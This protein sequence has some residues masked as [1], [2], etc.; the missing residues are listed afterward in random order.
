MAEQNKDFQEAFDELALAYEDDSDMEPTYD[1]LMSESEDSSEENKNVEE[2]LVETEE[3]PVEEPITEEVTDHTLQTSELPIDYKELYEKAKRDAEAQ[4]GLYASRLEN[5]SRQYA[6]LKETVNKAPKTQKEEREELPDNVKELFEIHPE[7]AEAVKSLV[8][9]K[10]S[11]VTRQVENEIKTRVEPVQ[12]QVY[13]T[14]Q[15]RHINTIRAAHPDLNAIMDSGD[16]VKW[17]QT[18]PSVMRT[19]ATYVYQYGSAEEIIGLLND[20]KAARGVKAPQ[21]KAVPRAQQANPVE[22]T[23]NIVKQ[24][25]AAMTVRTSKEPIDLG[26]KSRRPREKTF[27]EIAREYEQSRRVR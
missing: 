22:D 10:V 2:T 20:Y 1:E 27:D 18:L 19:G 17:I 13:M 14:E 6:E 8:E 26:N 9:N 5:L 23:E 3:Q 4:A 11:A 7:I 12:Q 16:L 21:A 15:Q 25:L 24:V